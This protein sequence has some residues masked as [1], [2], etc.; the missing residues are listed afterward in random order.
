MKLNNV[1]RTGALAAAVLTLSLGLTACGSDD[2]PTA[3]SDSFQRRSAFSTSSAYDLTPLGASAA[4]F[5]AAT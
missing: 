1:H 4:S 3:S 5:T 2:E